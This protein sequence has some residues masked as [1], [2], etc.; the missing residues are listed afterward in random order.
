MKIT[1]HRYHIVVIGHCTTRGYM[2]LTLTIMEE[3]WLSL[4]H[5]VYQKRF[6][7]WANT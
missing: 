1:F 5:R 4:I 2:M 3:K 7:S 6:F